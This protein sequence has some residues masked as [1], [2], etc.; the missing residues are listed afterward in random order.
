MNSVLL[1]WQNKEARA[2]RTAAIL[3]ALI[4]LDSGR[5][6][7]WRFVAIRVLLTIA[8]ITLK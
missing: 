5:L 3:K 4:A 2:F 7:A 8:A 6:A 1:G